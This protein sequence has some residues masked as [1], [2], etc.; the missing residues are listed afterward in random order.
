MWGSAMVPLEDINARR[1]YD[2]LAKSGTTRDAGY[3][4]VDLNSVLLMC[5]ILRAGEDFASALTRGK[6]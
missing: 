4:I 6:Q 2:F 5:E 1:G 3:P